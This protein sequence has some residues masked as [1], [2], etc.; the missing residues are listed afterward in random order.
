MA[1]K[2]RLQLLIDKE[3]LNPNQ[4]YIKTGLGNG[5]LN[6]VGEKLRKP[7]VE[8]IEKSFPHWNIDYIQTGKGEI[9]KEIS[10]GINVIGDGNISNTGTISGGINLSSDQENKILKKRIKELEEEVKQLKVD[11]AILQEFV[12]ILQSTNKK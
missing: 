5:F 10:S 9:F 6:T 1:L 11:K 8:K 2:D 3:G 4:F 7:S 12:N